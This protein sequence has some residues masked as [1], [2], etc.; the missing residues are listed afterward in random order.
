MLELLFLR[1]FYKWLAN[2]AEAKNRTRSWG[3]LGVLGWFGGEVTGFLMAGEAGSGGAYGI[4]LACGA[5]GAAVIA[6]TLSSLP[7]LTKPD[8]PNARIV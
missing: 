7:S 2:S 8:F 6:I 4:A 3:W 1:W 5:L